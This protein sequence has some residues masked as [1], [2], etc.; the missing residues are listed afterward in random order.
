MPPLL[1]HT[2]FVLPDEYIANNRP[3]HNE[4]QYP[5]DLARDKMRPDI[6]IVE[7]D[8]ME[9]HTEPLPQHARKLWLVEVGYCAN[10]KYEEKLAEKRQQHKTLHRM[11]QSSGYDVIMPPITQGFSGTIYMSTLECMHKLRIDQ[12]S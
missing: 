11:M 12:F 8:A 5:R 10:T 1:L 7:M 6:M 4:E 2:N 3:D 9:Q